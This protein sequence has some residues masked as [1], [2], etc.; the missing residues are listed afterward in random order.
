MLRASLRNLVAHKLRLFLTALSIVLAVAFVAGTYVFTDS[1]RASLDTLIQ[2]N[3]PDVTIRPTSDNFEK[4]IPAKKLSLEQSLEFC[5]DDECVEVTPD[6]VRI[7]KVVLDAGE[8]NRTAARL[9]KA[10][11]S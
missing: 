1:L 10:N 5:R 3:Q 7:R 2:Q 11:K 9:R 4:L 8:R 6:A